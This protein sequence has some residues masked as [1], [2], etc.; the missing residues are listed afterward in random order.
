MNDAARALAE[1]AASH[2]TPWRRDLDEAGSLPGLTDLEPAPWNE[3]LGPVIARGAPSGMLARGG[4]VLAEWGDVDRVEM[5]FSVAKSYLALLAGIAL[6]EGRM[7][8]LD[9]PVAEVVPEHFD[10]PHNTVITWRHLLEQTSEWEGTLWD[11]PDLVDRHRQVGPMADNRLKGTHRDLQPPGTFWEYNDVRVN[12]LSLS[13]MHAFGE[14]LP[15]VLWTRIMAP[16][17]ASR[18]WHWHGYR[19]STIE[20][21]GKRM[22]SVPGGTHWGGGLHICTRDHMHVAQL[23]LAGGVHG[24]RQLLPAGWTD[25]LRQPSAIN[26]GYGLLWWL[27]TD[28]AAWPAVSASAFAAIGAGGHLILID[29]EPGLALVSRWVEPDATA[30]LVE[31]AVRA[32]TT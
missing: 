3:L 20:L 7:A 11:K 18:Q 26:P 8:S 15:D 23:V 27:N 25:A 24:D 9:A 30:E 13:L 12:L 31:L 6:D 21:N 29:P 22:Q 28:R 14:A 10:T 16:L 19:N 32:A 4:S 2:E 5:T 1:F 17:G